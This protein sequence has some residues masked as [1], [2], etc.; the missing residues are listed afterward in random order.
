MSIGHTSI[1]PIIYNENT[2]LDYIQRVKFLLSENMA[3]G[4]FFI[5]I[6]GALASTKSSNYCTYMYNLTC[7]MSWLL[8]Y[9]IIVLGKLIL[10]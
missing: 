8:Y 5:L 10:L 9:P 3:V 1:K 6:D 7:L 4:C 2:K